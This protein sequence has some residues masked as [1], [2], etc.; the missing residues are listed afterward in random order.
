MFYIYV[1]QWITIIT[2]SKEINLESWDKIWEL[3]QWHQM[4][5][6]IWTDIK[7]KS[8]AKENRN[9]A[10]FQLPMTSNEILADFWS[11]DRNH[12]ALFEWHQMTSDL[13]SSEILVNAN[14]WAEELEPV[15]FLAPLVWKAWTHLVAEETG[16]VPVLLF[17]R[18]ILKIWI[19]WE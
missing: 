19:F 8:W 17:V 18:E 16:L 13:T 6:Y 9:Q 4:A 7:L 11:Y 2:L 14:I 1:L 12:L 10:L 5:S 3:F 15:G